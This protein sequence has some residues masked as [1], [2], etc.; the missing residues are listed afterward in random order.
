MRRHPGPRQLLQGQGLPDLRLELSDDTPAPHR[1]PH[2]PR[3][4]R[5]GLWRVQFDQRDDLYPRQPRGL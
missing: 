1:R 2:H 3:A 5:P 4:A